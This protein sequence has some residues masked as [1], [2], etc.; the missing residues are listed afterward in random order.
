MVDHAQEENKLMDS[1]PSGGKQYYFKSE[2]RE[3]REEGRKGY[4]KFPYHS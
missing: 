3:R 2:H 4:W 1:D